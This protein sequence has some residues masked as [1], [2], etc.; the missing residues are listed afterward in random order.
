V[1]LDIDDLVLQEHK[2]DEHSLKKSMLEEEGLKHRLTGRIETYIHAN[3][4]Y[5]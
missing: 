4:D 3:G 5:H 1:E 2:T